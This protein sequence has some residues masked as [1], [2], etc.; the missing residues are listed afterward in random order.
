MLKGTL[1][2]QNF[3]AASNVSFIKKKKQYQHALQDQMIQ[4][5]RQSRLNVHQERNVH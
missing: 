4:N 5:G 3:K 2:W 1:F